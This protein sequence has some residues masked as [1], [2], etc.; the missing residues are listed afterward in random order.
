M[1]AA[2]RHSRQAGASFCVLIGGAAL[3]KCS[4]RYFTKPA[5]VISRD[6]YH[7]FCCFGGASFL[8]GPVKEKKQKKTALQWLLLI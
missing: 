7:P 3:P 8:S 4:A 2:K 5:A 6:A 1:R